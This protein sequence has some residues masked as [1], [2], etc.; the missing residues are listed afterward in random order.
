LNTNLHVHSAGEQNTK[1]PKYQFKCLI[2]HNEKCGRE[3]KWKYGKRNH[4]LSPHGDEVV[5]ITAI[6]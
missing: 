2:L 5:A 6:E 4:D 3:E 1:P